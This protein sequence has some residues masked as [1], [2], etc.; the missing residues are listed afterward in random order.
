VFLT[1]QPSYF[2]WDSVPLTRF[3][4]FPWRLLSLVGLALALMA[5]AGTCVLDALPKWT[6]PALVVFSALAVPGFTWDYLRPPY[7]T[8]MPDQVLERQLQQKIVTTT[9]QNEFLPRT[10][11]Y[12]PAREGRFERRGGEVKIA[13]GQGMVVSVF[14]RKNGMPRRFGLRALTPLTLAWG[15]FFFPGWRAE[16]DGIL[17][18]VTFAAR[19]GFILVDV[20]PG[21]H[22]VEFI[23]ADTPLRRWA[24]IA[25]LLSLIVVLVL[26]AS[27]GALDLR[28]VCT[29]LRNR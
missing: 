11:R 23:F 28:R 22:V 21:D 7:D 15:H 25:S 26:V 19:G 16:I 18:S 29:P 14:P 17:T 4:Q 10:A 27:P 20:P 5:G 12:F 24:K 3:V 1:V 6:R 13:S 9:A 8:D 2:L